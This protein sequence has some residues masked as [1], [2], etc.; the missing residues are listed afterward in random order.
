[1][2]KSGNRHEPLFDI[3]P[4]TGARFEVFY[5]DSPPESFG[6]GGAGWLWQLRR[7]GFAPDSPARGPFSTCY[8]AYRNA[9]LLIGLGA[10][11]GTAIE[12][13]EFSNVI[14]S[15]YKAKMAEGEI[16]G[17]NLLLVA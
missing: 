7:R 12:M 17:S 9:V 1:M 16:L 10:D 2:T 8:S 11:L 3:H 15:R 13:T 4:V 14:S 5:A 6:R